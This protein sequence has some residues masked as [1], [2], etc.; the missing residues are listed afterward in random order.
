M[1]SATARSPMLVA[2][3]LHCQPPLLLCTVNYRRVSPCAGHQ[4]AA[5]PACSCCLLP[6]AA[7]CCCLPVATAEHLGEHS[8]YTLPQYLAIGQCD[9]G[10]SADQI[11]TVIYNTIFVNQ[12]WRAA[13]LD[14]SS[15]GYTW[16]KHGMAALQCHCHC[17]SEP[18]KEIEQW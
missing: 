9:G 5:H 12:V 13:K 4:Y 7:V 10:L 16:E 1:H 15:C 17:A 11:F 2:V 14:C 3:I 6:L 18:T 8:T